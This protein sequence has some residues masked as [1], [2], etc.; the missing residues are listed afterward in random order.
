MR[1]TNLLAQTRISC[2]SILLVILPLVSNGQQNVLINMAAVD[3]VTI[4]PDNIFN[5]QVQSSGPGS[6][7]VRGTIRYR[8][9]NLNLSYSFTT[10]LRPGINIFIPD[11]VHPQ[12]Q[13]SS[14]AL[15]ELFFTYKI[16]P[17]GTF[18]YCVTITPSNVVKE[19][20]G[21]VFD[22]CL[23][24]RAG[25]V[26]LINLLEPENR[27]KLH[28][29]NPMLSWVA[30]YSFS[31][32]LT[33]RIRVAEIKQEQNPENAVLRNQPVYDEHNLMQNSIVYPVY[34][35]P[36][37]ADKPYAWTVDA[38]YKGILLGGAEAWQ[39]II[40]TDT[41]PDK[42]PVR[43]SYVDIKIENGTTRL[44]IIGELKIKYVLEKLKKDELTLRLVDES[45]NDVPM[46]PDKLNA[47]Y[48][49]NR[50]IL[51]LKDSC[52]LKH[53]KEYKLFVSSKTGEH[54]SLPF[55]YINPEYTH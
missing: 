21:G 49:D 25:D 29:F 28:E 16:L 14:S 43:R 26:F 6:V 55:K 42:L 20:P 11:E 47:V 33:Y 3:G 1:Q 17:E 41:L 18:E 53:M 48:G 5:Y 12:W 10:M 36:L 31:N 24:H 46:N 52:N 38:Y 35:R 40:P 9:S 51:N 8:N 7:Q 22:E 37:E 32:E 50:Y 34:A 27:A 39:F 13:F 30:N 2:L 54:Y 23:Y 44:N 15:Q 19:N 45:N 4:T